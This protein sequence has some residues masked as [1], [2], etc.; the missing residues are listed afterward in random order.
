MAG[1]ARTPLPAPSGSGKVPAIPG[2]NI[3]IPVA[4]DRTDKAGKSATG[5]M[6]SGGD[7]IR[8]MDASD[9]KTPPKKTGITLID[10]DNQQ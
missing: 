5:A 6:Q 4:G 2:W 8:L 9:A 7:Q 3:K 10:N 1:N